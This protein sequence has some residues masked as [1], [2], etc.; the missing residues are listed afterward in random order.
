LPAVG[1][2]LPRRAVP[3]C[4]HSAHYDTRTPLA[5]RA[6]SFTPFYR[7]YTDARP[8]CTTLPAAWTAAPA[9]HTFTL[10]ARTAVCCLTLPSRAARTPPCLPCT[11]PHILPPC[12]PHLP[13]LPHCHT[14]TPACSPRHTAPYL[15]RR[16]PPH[17]HLP[18]AL[19]PR[20]AAFAAAF[21]L[22]ACLAAP[23]ACLP[24]AS[25]PLRPCLPY[26][27]ARA[28][29]DMHLAPTLR[30]LCCL[31]TRLPAWRRAPCRVPYHPSAFYLWFTCHA[32]PCYRRYVPC[33]VHLPYCY[34][35]LA[36]FP[37]LPQVP[38]CLCSV[39]LLI[40][41][42]PPATHAH[43]PRLPYHA[44][45][46]Y[47]RTQR[48]ASRMPCRCRCHA[49][50]PVAAYHLLHLRLRSLEHGHV[51]ARVRDIG[52][53]ASRLRRTSSRLYAY[54]GGILA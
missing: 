21:C 26:A 27:H 28:R 46:L 52:I 49:V 22:C 40:T 16:T 38:A 30:H 1:L 37:A 31:H 7:H 34:H 18:Y 3:R 50:P 12:C 35:R 5:R 42:L 41:H 9:A 33:R 36:A 20:P 32:H 10:P 51:T 6:P 53:T 11:R 39:T 4:A 25:L 44:A 2:P 17:T 15:R 29:S 43:F 23:P 13:T 48:Y 8:Y 47:A 24:M 19:L 14:A 54:F 45:R